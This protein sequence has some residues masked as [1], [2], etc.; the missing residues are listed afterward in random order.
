[1]S[2]HC[3]QQIAPGPWAK[4][5]RHAGKINKNSSSIHTVKNVVLLTVLTCM[6]HAHP[7][8]EAEEID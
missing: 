1:M 3:I 7:F 5:D 6:N 8:G 2:D 4:Q